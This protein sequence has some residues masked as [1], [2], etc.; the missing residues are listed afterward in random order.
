MEK[1]ATMQPV[2]V[3]E[4]SAIEGGQSVGIFTGNMGEYLALQKNGRCVSDCPNWVGPTPTILVEDPSNAATVLVVRITRKG[5]SLREVAPSIVRG[6][7][8]G[9]TRS[10]NGDLSN[11]WPTRAQIRKVPVFTS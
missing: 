10:E 5:R 8:Y 9:T 7:G 2:E 3:N 11:L 6:D 1:N 4:L